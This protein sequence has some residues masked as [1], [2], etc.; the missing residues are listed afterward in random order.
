[1][2]QSHTRHDAVTRAEQR[3]QSA[4]SRAPA[5]AGS[6]SDRTAWARPKMLLRRPV[7]RRP[8]APRRSGPLKRIMQRDTASQSTFCTSTRAISS[9]G[10]RTVVRCSRHPPDVERLV[11]GIGRSTISRC[12]GAPDQRSGAWSIRRAGDGASGSR[13]SARSGART[14]GLDAGVAAATRTPWAVGAVGSGGL[15][16]APRQ[17]SASRHPDVRGLGPQ[18]GDA[19]DGAPH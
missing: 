19:Q 16:R 12:S 10:M 9:V 7:P 2:V 14:N 6:G 13:R 3:G 5:A 11:K 15:G 17:G 18:V 1:M 8:G 4:R